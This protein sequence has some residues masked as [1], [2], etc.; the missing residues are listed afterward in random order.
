MEWSIT[1][2]VL[3]SEEENIESVGFAVDVVQSDGVVRGV[4]GGCPLSNP[5]PL[6]TA[7]DDLLLEE[8]FLTLGA[9]KAEHENTVL[10]GNEP[11]LEYPWPYQ[12]REVLDAEQE[13]RNRNG[14]LELVVDPI[15]CN[16]LRW[17]AM[18]EAKQAEW[19]AYRQDLL[20]ITEQDDFPYNIT[21]PTKPE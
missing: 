8:L 7:T 14:L 13:R 18:T 1:S 19:L 12:P 6:A 9:T 4:T 20:N 17:D 5:V 15:I 3:D 16:P 11:A 10:S 2:V 21:W